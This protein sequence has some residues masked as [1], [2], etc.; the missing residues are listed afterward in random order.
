MTVT[1]NASN[2]VK[3]I[4]EYTQLAADDDDNENSDDNVQIHMYKVWFL[5][6]RLMMGMMIV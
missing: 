2:I 5:A 4:S 3:A 1:D 6:M